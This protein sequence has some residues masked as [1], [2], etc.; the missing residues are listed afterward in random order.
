MDPQSPFN[1]VDSRTLGPGEQFSILNE[2]ADTGSTSPWVHVRSSSRHL[3]G[4][5]TFFDAA[6]SLLG[7]TGIVPAAP[8]IFVFPEAGLQSS[9]RFSIGNTGAE[10]ATLTF[11]LRNEGGT[12][13]SVTSRDIPATGSLEIESLVGF[14]ADSSPLPS[15]YVR[16]LST[17][18]IAA[19]E[20]GGEEDNGF[21]VLRALAETDAGTVLLCPQF[22]VGP[23]WL[24]QLSAVNLDAISGEV[25]VEFIGEDGRAIGSAR[26]LTIPPNG[27][28][29]LAGGDLFGIPAGEFREGF[30]VIRSSGVR[31]AG[32]VIFK[33][34][35]EERFAAALPL[36]ARPE[37]SQLVG[38]LAT[39]DEYFTGLAMLNAADTGTT[40]KLEFY[41]A[42]GRLELVAVAGL[43]AGRRRVGLLT[44]FFP[45]LIGANR[46]FGYVRICSEQPLAN[47]VL[48]GARDLSFLSAIPSQPVQ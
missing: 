16:V 29:Q 47:Y 25:S 3:V 15:D 43:A 19:Y 14:F 17:G 12:L 41:D 13:K 31:L 7:G 42:G 4:S 21:Y 38:H 30:L 32:N 18:L 26:S 34:A 36:I 1:G 6:S 37:R 20:F 35:G 40:V 8:G 27:K 33:D 44:E 46:R 9:A 23:G 24:S 48:S 45:S 11:E 22:L 39:D 5:L 2:D 28:L 10:T